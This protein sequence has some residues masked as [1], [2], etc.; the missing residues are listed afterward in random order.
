MRGVNFPYRG[1]NGWLVWLNLAIPCV[2]LVP[3][4]IEV[5]MW[6]LAASKVNLGEP[7]VVFMGVSL[8]ILWVIAQTGYVACIPGVLAACLLLIVPGIPRKVRLT[9]A[10]LNVAACIVLV[11]D[12]ARLRAQLNRGILGSS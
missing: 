12:V 2:V 3:I 9:M 5:C 1:P 6:A 8:V 10:A 7:G 4:L 11:L